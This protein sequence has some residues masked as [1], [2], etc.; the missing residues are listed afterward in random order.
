MPENVNEWFWVRVKTIPYIVIY[1][2]N[3]EGPRIF[4]YRM[5]TFTFLEDEN[6]PFKT[7]LGDF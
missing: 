1:I 4:P 7:L 2:K 3:N 5:S 6:L